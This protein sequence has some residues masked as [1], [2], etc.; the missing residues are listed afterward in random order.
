[1]WHCLD[2]H[3]DKLFNAHCNW[4]SD[5]LKKTVSATC[6]L[7][8]LTFFSKLSQ[9]SNF[10]SKSMFCLVILI[11]KFRVFHYWEILISIPKVGRLKKLMIHSILSWNFS[12]MTFWIIL[13]HPNIYAVEL[14]SWIFWSIMPR[15]IILNRGWSVETWKGDFL[16]YGYNIIFIKTKIN[17][18]KRTF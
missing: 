17:S 16:K 11:W 9:H 8:C 2:L 10:L 15:K 13:I 1:M 5:H 12:S 14:R 7:N 3:E 18:R 6:W 4:I